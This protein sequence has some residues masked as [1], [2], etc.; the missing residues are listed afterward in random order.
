MCFE[1]DVIQRKIKGVFER[2][3]DKHLDSIEITDSALGKMT[4][5]SFR[6]GLRLVRRALLE[7]L[8]RQW[9]QG[10]RHFALPAKAESLRHEF[11]KQFHEKPFF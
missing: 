3:P 6:C 10:R 5:S 4:V 7:N 8:G 9:R 11:R 2:L 1:L